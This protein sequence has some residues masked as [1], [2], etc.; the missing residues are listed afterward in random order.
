MGE[1]LIFFGITLALEMILITG[2]NSF[3]I[4]LLNG[5]IAFVAMFMIKIF[6][7]FIFKKESMGGGDIKLLFFF[8]FCLGWAN[9]LLSIFFGSLAGFPISLV[10]LKTKKTN[11]IPFGPF[12]AIGAAIILLTGFDINSLINV[13][14]TM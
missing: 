14:T 13:L 9:A 12:L 3:L 10:V 4:N 6:G 5:I 1:I 11:I 7:D 2:F 8:G